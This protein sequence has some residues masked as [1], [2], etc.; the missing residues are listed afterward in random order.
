MLLLY[1]VAGLLIHFNQTP[2]TEMTTDLM[3][4]NKYTVGDHIRQ[5]EQGFQEGNNAL[6]RSRTSPLR[7]TEI[8][9]PPAG[10][11]KLGALAV[12]KWLAE[13]LILWSH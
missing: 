9:M 8:W 4:H 2:V 5:S 3:A 10:K 13:I 12:I 11:P 1:K 7:T 6:G